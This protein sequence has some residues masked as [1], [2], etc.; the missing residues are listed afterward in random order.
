MPPQPLA[1]ATATERV[2]WPLAVL[3]SSCP[4]SRSHC[5]DSR[6]MA[7]MLW[8]ADGSEA[9]PR[10]GNATTVLRPCSPDNNSLV[11]CCPTT[12]SGTRWEAVSH[13]GREPLPMLHP[14][15]ACEPHKRSCRWEAV[16]VSSPHRPENNSLACPCSAIRGPCRQTGSGGLLTLRAQ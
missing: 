8:R 11:H 5:A 6:W 4:A 9:E 16:P 3:P 1:A 13:R 14:P 15:L 10:Y 2:P 12:T 7:R